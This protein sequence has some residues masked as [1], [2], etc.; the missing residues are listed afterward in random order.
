M[1]AVLIPSTTQDRASASLRPF[2]EKGHDTLATSRK[3]RP[4]N[5]TDIH[6]EGIL[7]PQSLRVTS[8]KAIIEAL[9]SRRRAERSHEMLALARGS[10]TLHTLPGDGSSLRHY[11]GW[12]AKTGP[13]S[14]MG[15]GVLSGQHTPLTI[16]L[17][18]QG[19]P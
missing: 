2:T 16:R 15:T 8:Q 12:P 1:A 5:L 3:E 14:Q 18:L 6:E 7:P 4:S 17:S 11:G 13:Q 9:N 19:R 10:S